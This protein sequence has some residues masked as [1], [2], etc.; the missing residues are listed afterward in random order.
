MRLSIKAEFE[1]HPLKGLEP[2]DDEDATEY[3]VRACLHFRDW[4]QSAL[5]VDVT[6]NTEPTK[7][8]ENEYDAGQ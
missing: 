2:Y 6:V 1:C 7:E 8:S 4:A 3:F 5:D